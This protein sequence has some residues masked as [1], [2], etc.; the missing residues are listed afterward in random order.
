MSQQLPVMACRVT[1]GSVFLSVGT[2]AVHLLDCRAFQALSGM[3]L[4]CLY[5]W[6]NLISIDSSQQQHVKALH[7]YS[8]SLSC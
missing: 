4:V 7:T 2:S 5:C 6:L 3:C 1:V 8:P